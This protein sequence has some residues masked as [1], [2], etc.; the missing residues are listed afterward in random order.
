M[1]FMDRISGRSQVAEGVGFG[2]IWYQYEVVGMRIST[3]KSEAIGLSQ[4]RVNCPLWV[5]GESLPQVEEFR[6]LEVLFTR[7]G[8]MEREIRRQ[9]GAASAVTRTLKQSV[10]AEEELSQKAKLSI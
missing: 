1:I 3:S 8:R 9:I 10:V 2:M 6:Y 7:E 4:K 5:G